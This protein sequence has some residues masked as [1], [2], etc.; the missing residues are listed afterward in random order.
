VLQAYRRAA[1]AAGDSAA[2]VVL[3]PG[4]HFEVI[5]PRTD[6]GKTAVGLALAAVGR[7]PRRLPPSPLPQ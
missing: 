2:V 4:G 6:A 3:V 1:G 5:A 7:S